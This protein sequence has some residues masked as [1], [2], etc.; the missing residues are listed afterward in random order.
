MSKLCKLLNMLAPLL[1][2]L[3]V[4]PASAVNQRLYLTDGSY[5]VVREYQ[6]LGDRVRF[7]S[8]ERSA[9]EE[10]PLELI[11]LKKTRAVNQSVL[12]EQA[13][14]QKLIDAED[15]VE[16]RLREEAYG[17]P[18]E[19]GVYLYEGEKLRAFPI[20]E[21]EVVTDKKRAVLKAINPLPLTSGK[22]YV[23]I[24]GERSA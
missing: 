14:E 13:K 8:T 22:N 24:K 21:L 18:A 4:Q 2:V 10:I 15:A 19:P 1:L 3:L 6:V 5:H 20:A 9:W 23:E 11:D 16:R 7:Y 12:D 17:I